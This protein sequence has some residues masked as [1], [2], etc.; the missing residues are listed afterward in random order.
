MNEFVNLQ[1]A[2]WARCNITNPIR[3]KVRFNSLPV[4]I[5]L[6]ATFVL[7][8]IPLISLP[9]SLVGVLIRDIFT[10]GLSVKTVVSLIFGGGIFFGCVMLLFIPVLY[11][12]NMRGE[13][14][15]TLTSEGIETRN[16]RKHTWENLSYINQVN[17]RRRNVGIV[18]NSFEI[19]FTTGK[20]IV[21]PLIENQVAL[22]QLVNSIPAERQSELR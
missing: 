22:V 8:A 13:I 19:V 3:V 7:F 4:Q 1:T 21:P 14:V 2:D 10:I 9:A 6:I 20:A 12:R 17:T 18:P 16:S 5:F 11:Y 15:K